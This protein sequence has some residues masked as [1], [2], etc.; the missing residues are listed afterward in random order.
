MTD[1]LPESFDSLPY[2]H[3]AIFETHPARIGAIARLL[4]QPAA[5]PDACRVLELG[6][7]E[8]MNLL[9]L[10]AHLP[11]SQF[12]GV[13]FSSGQIATAERTRVGAQLENVRFECADLRQWEPEPAAFDYIIA[14]G[15]YS[16]VP[17]D[18]KD[19]MMAICAKGLA[20]GGIAYASYNVYPGWGLVG[21]MR[22][23]ILAEISGYAAGD[24]REDR[25]QEVLRALDESFAGDERPYAALMRE[26]LAEMR[27][28]SRALL[29]HDELE[30]VNDP[31]TFLEF[32]EHAKRHRLQFLAEAHYASMPF[33]HV[34]PPVRQA[35]GALIPDFLRGQQLLDVIGNRRFRN[36]LLI[37]GEQEPE[38]VVKLDAIR[39]CALRVN[40]RVVDGKVDLQ[41]GVPMQVIGR[42]DVRMTIEK[43]FQKAFIAV[44]VAAAPE[45][46]PYA[47]ARRRAVDLLS[48]GGLPAEID[49]DFLCVACYRLF[50]L[51][52]LDLML[53][54]SGEWLSFA[55]K[56]APS[57]L[58]RYQSQQALPIANRWHE[59]VELTSTEK[60]WLAGAVV[61]VDE[62]RLATLGILV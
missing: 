58:L 22:K 25:A 29:H 19:R 33:E 55:E 7:A 35:L 9:P 39:D 31:C 56:P 27:G 59:T 36:T 38:R 21:A 47:E 44:L 49:D 6:C 14:H 24:A 13:D 34:R 42:H 11:G 61:R 28:K 57:P 45:R 48:R 17:D 30:T 51:D 3:G 37:A 15:V 10:A 8:G 20:P 5:A 52:Q 54:G 26:V 2:R 16:W 1:V 62:D 23:I 41:E 4:G 18:V 12:V 53:T 60:R 50:A 32:A 43:P 46:L 40:L